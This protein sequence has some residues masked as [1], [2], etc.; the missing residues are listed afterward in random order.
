MECRRPVAKE[1]REKVSQLNQ[2]HKQRLEK[3]K[4]EERD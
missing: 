2:T 1:E 4:D 3:K